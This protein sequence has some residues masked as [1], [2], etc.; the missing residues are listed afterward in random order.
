MVMVP[1]QLLLHEALVEDI[2]LMPTKEG[3]T[4]DMGAAELVKHIVSVGAAPL[5]SRISAL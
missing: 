3:P 4:I 1:S 2:L 5:F